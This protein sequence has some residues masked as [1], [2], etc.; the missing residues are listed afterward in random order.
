MNDNYNFWFWLDVISNLAQLESYRILL[1]DF[2]NS[3]L[4][5]YLK[6]QDTLMNEIINQN[7]QILDILKGN[8]GV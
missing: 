7:K 3:D 8:R 2:D 1:E 6:H 5:K 4:M